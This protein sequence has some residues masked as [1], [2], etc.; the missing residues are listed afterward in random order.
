MSTLSEA[1]DDSIPWLEV[2]KPDAFA[3]RSMSLSIGR[4]VNLGNFENVKIEAGVSVDILAVDADKDAI[5]AKMIEECRAGL[6]QA[7]AAQKK[8][9]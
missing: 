6:N 5:R 8:P 9:K 3:I 4:T 7:F 2:E 1:L